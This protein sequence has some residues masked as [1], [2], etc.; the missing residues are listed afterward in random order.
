[1]T[2][3]SSKDFLANGQKKK[4]WTISWSKNAW[5]RLVLPPYFWISKA[6]PIGSWTHCCVESGAASSLPW[7]NLPPHCC[8]G[9]LWFDRIE[10]LSV[11]ARC[12]ASH[13]FRV[14]FG[15]RAVEQFLYRPWLLNWFIRWSTW[16]YA[17]LAAEATSCI[18]Y[19][20]ILCLAQHNVKIRY[21]IVSFASSIWSRKHT[22]SNLQMWHFLHGH[23][24]LWTSR[25]ERGDQQF[26]VLLIC[27]I[28]RITPHIHV[29]L[30]AW[31]KR[32]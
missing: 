9:S 10:P 16:R 11:V 14:R 18:K 25:K 8:T 15:Q 27:K 29:V 21:T 4:P 7:K 23:H 17:S 1:M 3:I 22:A 19:S 32:C 30:A 31:S 2:T 5:V 28:R 20:F 24:V 13:G 12:H 6:G 26:Q